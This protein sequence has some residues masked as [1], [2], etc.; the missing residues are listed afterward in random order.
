[1]AQADYTLEFENAGDTVYAL[2]AAAAG[3]CFAACNSGLYR[4]R[5]FGGTWERLP[6]SQE[7]ATTAVAISPNFASDRSVFA[8][9]KGG[10]R[11]SSDAGDTWFTTA[12]PA[13]P[14]L[15]SSLVVSPDFERDGVLLAGTLEDGVFASSDRG[16]H[17]Q[18]WNFG[19]FDLN[20]LS[21]AISPHWRDDETVYA[22]TETGLYRSSNGGRAW[23]FTNY[24]SE[25]APV[26]SLAIAAD[27]D[28][29]AITLFAGSES[30]GLL[31]SCDEGASWRLLAA[32]SLS[33]A[34]NQLLLGSD[35]G[36][37]STLYVMG[38]DGL[39]RSD[40]HGVTWL[41]VLQIEDSPTAM[42]C[43]DDAMLV[44][45]LGKGIIRIPLR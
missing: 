12:F 44:G 27:H 11:R 43:L 9:V 4:S 41:T 22:G 40:D 15:F 38:D 13:P 5:D 19:L 36:G 29:G 21:L 18:P 8:A 1:M 31:A 42:L 10:I 23:R 34:V 14:P 45:I 16:V 39:M 30:Q 35:D 7:H 20:V 25:S 2:A 6:V 3:A 17:W 26:L 37:D 28:S 33:G 32:G 24:P